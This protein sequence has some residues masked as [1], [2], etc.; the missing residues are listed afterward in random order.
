MQIR[1]TTLAKLKSLYFRGDMRKLAELT[2]MHQNSISY[3][4]RTGRTN[5]DALELILGFYQ[6]RENL[7]NQF[8]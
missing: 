6:H 7:L 4:F 3:F 5:P 8:E 1:E 2:G